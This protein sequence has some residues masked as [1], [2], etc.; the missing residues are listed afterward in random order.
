[1]ETVVE[2]EKSKKRK[3]IGVTKFIK[4]VVKGVKDEFKQVADG[5]DEAIGDGVKVDKDIFNNI[6]KVGCLFGDSDD[7]ETLL[8]KNI[9]K[10]EREE[11]LREHQ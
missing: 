9:I 8:E 1:M 10:E 6:K 7:E 3:N 2:K 5:F 4:S 11:W